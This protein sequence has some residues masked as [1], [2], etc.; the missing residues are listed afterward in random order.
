MALLDNKLRLI[1]HFES[2]VEQN[3]IQAGQCQTG[4]VGSEP[5][6]HRRWAETFVATGSSRAG[7]WLTG[8]SPKPGWLCDWLSSGCGFAAFEAF[9]A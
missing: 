7:R 5:Q 3:S 6:I 2:L 9:Q 8:Y 1:K 4:V